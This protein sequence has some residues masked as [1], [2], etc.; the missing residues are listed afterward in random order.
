MQHSTQRLP[1][2][3]IAFLLCLGASSCMSESGDR[4][5]TEQGQIHTSEGPHFIQGVC[6]HPVAIGEDK[7]SF[8]SLTQDLALM[9]EMGVN[10]LRVY[11][12]IASKSVLDQ[13]SE[14]GMKVIIGFGYNQDGVYDLQSGTYLDYIQSFKSHPAILFWELGNEYNFHPEWFGGSLD[15]WYQALRTAAECD[16]RGRPQP[17]R[18]HR[19]R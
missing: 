5:W 17:S 11:E 19:A 18:G 14:A 2:P 16:P 10:T 3:F 4:V 12:P 9:K 6:Y 8:E 13:I 1:F 15:V 7:R